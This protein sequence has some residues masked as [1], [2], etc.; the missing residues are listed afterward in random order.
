MVELRLLSSR[1]GAATYAVTAACGCRLPV[2]PCC[3][4]R[5]EWGHTAG[6]HASGSRCPDKEL[7]SSAS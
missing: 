3:M 6:Q 7:C 1:T 2:R 5:Q 4:Q